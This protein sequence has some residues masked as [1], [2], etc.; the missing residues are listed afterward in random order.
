MLPAQSELLLAAM[1]MSGRYDASALLIAATL[2][3]VAGSTVNWG[4]GRFLEA[5]RDARWF[6]IPRAALDR[7]ERWYG[8]WGSWS[9][10]LSWVP[11]IGDP[12]TLVAGILRTPFWKFVAVVTLAK[13]GRYIMIALAMKAPVH[14]SDTD[15]R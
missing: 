4:I 13:A 9:L 15:S 10:F 5:Q 7:A 11:V 2:G 12:L 14:Y 6:P 1:L 8:Q 3:N